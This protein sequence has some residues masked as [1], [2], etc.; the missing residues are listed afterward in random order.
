MRPASLAGRPTSEVKAAEPSHFPLAFRHRMGETPR[1]MLLFFQGPSL[2]LLAAW[3]LLA[4]AAL[5]IAVLFLF[6]VLTEK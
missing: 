6:Y 5:L 4:G 1:P 2:L 3:V